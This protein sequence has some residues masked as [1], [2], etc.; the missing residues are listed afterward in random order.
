MDD[1][2]S[3]PD[4]GLKVEILA[5]TGYTID[6]D[7]ASDEWVIQDDDDPTWSVTRN[8]DSISENGGTARITIGTGGVVTF[9]ADQTITTG[10]VGGRTPD[11]DYTL[12]DKDGNTLSDPWSVTLPAGDSSTY[13]TMTGIDD[14]EAELDV[15]AF[16]NFSHDGA[17]IG[18][19]AEKIVIEDDDRVDVELSVSPLEVAEAAGATT[20]T[21]TGTLPLAT[22]SAET[23]VEVFDVE[24]SAT[25]TTDYT[26]VPSTIRLTFAAAA[27]SATGTFTLT[28]VSDSDAELNETVGFRGVAED[29][30]TGSAHPDVLRNIRIVHVHIIDDDRSLNSLV[31]NHS[32]SSSNPIGEYP[33]AGR[34]IAQE[35]GTGANAA[36]YDLTGIELRLGAEG[37]DHKRDSLR[38]T[39]VDLYSASG[40]EPDSMIVRLQNPGD[41]PRRQSQPLP[42]APRHDARRQHLLLRRHLPRRRGARRTGTSRHGIEQ[43]E[44]G[45]G[46]EHRQR[47]ARERRHHLE[48]RPATP[49]RS[50]SLGTPY[51]A[52]TRKTPRPT[53]R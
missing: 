13:V 19:G 38:R 16:I 49:S 50:R 34:T 18:E 48:H 21:V 40:G 23:E 47:P 53:P 33:A 7:N 4:G 46:L 37:L 26:V 6:A 20:V 22:F 51:R 30:N 14:S 27:T 10:F 12:K 35:F 36:G 11:V 52:A 28:P 8:K 2:V 15:A 42:G 3:E 5:G 25:R 43:P 41:L 1:N 24:G 17:Q 29:P 9:S 45:L 31:A 39:D 44:R 32:Q